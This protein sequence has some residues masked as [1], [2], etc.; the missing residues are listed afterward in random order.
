MEVKAKADWEDALSQSRHLLTIE[1]EDSWLEQPIV[2]RGVISDVASD[3][4]N[5]DQYIL[6]LEEARPQAWGRLPFRVRVAAPKTAIDTFLETHP[7]AVGGWRDR[8]AAIVQIDNVSTELF[9]NDDEV[10]RLHVGHGRL[11]HI[12][13]LVQ[14]P[15]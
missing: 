6:V 3:V 4:G 2:F 15:S 10:Q 5:L 9:L 12:L 1:L 8:V 11:L 7:N 13:S 14:P